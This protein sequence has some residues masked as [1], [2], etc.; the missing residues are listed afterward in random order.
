MTTLGYVPEAQ[1]RPDDDRVCPRGTRESILADIETWAGD[2]SGPP[3]YWLTGPRHTGKST[4]AR[5][6][7]RRLSDN[8]S[9]LVASFF[10]S[11]DSEDRRNLLS[12]APTLAFQL[13]HRCP[14]FR[15]ALRI[16]KEYHSSFKL[17][18]QMS[19]LLFQPLRE[20]A[21]STTIVID[22]LDECKDGERILSLLWRTASELPKVKFLV[23]ARPE[24]GGVQQL[25]NLLCEL[26]MVH[27]FFLR[28]QWVPPK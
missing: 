25:F 1:D 22:A 10:C 17:E 23:T 26:G 2:C 4:I 3:I 13:G 6:I 16:R 21:V 28:R 24:H 9:S 20:S 8:R 11:Q 5:T 12:I 15:S 7:A 27:V 14:K 18:D 19:D